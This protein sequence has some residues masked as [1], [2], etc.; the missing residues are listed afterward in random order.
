MKLLIRLATAT[1]LALA[2]CT[3]QFTEDV[4]DAAQ[5]GFTELTNG[6]RV[7]HHRH[8]HNK[9]RHNWHHHHHLRRPVQ[10]R[11]INLVCE[12]GQVIDKIKCPVPKPLCSESED[13][14][15]ALN[16]IPKKCSKII[17]VT[18]IKVPLPCF[19]KPEQVCADQVDG[20]SAAGTPDA[21][22][23]EVEI[24]TASPENEPAAE[25]NASEDG[26]NALETDDDGNDD[27][28]D[29]DTVDAA[30]NHKH[31]HKK[32]GHKK[33]HHNRHKHKH[34]WR[35]LCVL[36][37]TFCGS[38]LFGCKF[39]PN[40]VHACDRIGDRPR[41]LYTCPGQCKQ[42]L[43]V[44]EPTGTASTATPTATAGPSSSVS[45]AS[46][47]TSSTA[48]A[49]TTS[50]TSS[51]Q[52]TS[53]STSSYSSSKTSSTSSSSSS[54]T[55]STSSSSTSK[56][57]S[58]SS[59]SSTSSQSTA[60]ATQSSSTS[61]SPST[62]TATSTSS[63]STGTATITGSATTSETAT[64]TGSATA[65]DT[66]TTTGSTTATDTATTTGD[67]NN[68]R[69]SYRNR[70]SYYNRVGYRNRYGHNN[71]VSYRN[72]DCHYNRA[73]YNNQTITNTAASLPAPY[74]A[75]FQ[76]AATTIQTI[77]QD[78]AAATDAQ[79]GAIASS[80]VQL[81]NALVATIAS[82]QTALTA[83]GVPAAALTA[84]TDALNAILAAAQ[85]VVTCT[86]APKD[87]TGLIKLAGA[88]IKALLSFFQTATMGIPGA[89]QLLDLLN[90]AAD[91][92]ITGSAM[93]MPALEGLLGSI[94]TFLATIGLPDAAKV[95]L[96]FIKSLIQAIIDCL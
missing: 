36:K 18:N 34:H 25:V 68:N 81:I 51:S 65:T 89:T 53:S 5:D 86:A 15:S 87:C 73:S 71:R 61:S 10:C 44:E 16:N 33:H 66:A 35:D 77:T 29:D 7:S 67:R 32:H 79:A 90:G 57:S 4:S 59:T 60:T 80:L 21:Q 72:R 17:S 27:S 96:N 45:S 20:V 6:H 55:S 1:L 24:A 91:T 74:N 13:A 40:A 31:G 85:T 83:L 22:N 88:I 75:L 9:W 41:V 28:E 70:D 14:I 93:T 43:C 69:I 46:Q 12:N 48:S 58:S 26:D 2:A 50:S 56:S 49:S 47:S 62:N 23:D 78:L 82:F 95:P 39:T 84:I 64:T 11:E 54:K 52:S 42:G 8:R 76:A 37:G 38:D 92:L 19:K 63:S 30:W 94:T 3:A